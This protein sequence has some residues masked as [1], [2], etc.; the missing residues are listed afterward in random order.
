M[1]LV[2]IDK[3]IIVFTDKKSVQKDITIDINV[4]RP[5][6]KNIRESKSKKTTFWNF[7]FSLTFLHG[8]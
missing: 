8:A 7:T 6:K 1:S 2:W 5:K 4:L 3:N